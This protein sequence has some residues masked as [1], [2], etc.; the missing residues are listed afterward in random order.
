MVQGQQCVRLVVIPMH[1]QGPSAWV[2][3]LVMLSCP[4]AGDPF[5]TV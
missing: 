4:M 3:H 2:V 1:L 5:M